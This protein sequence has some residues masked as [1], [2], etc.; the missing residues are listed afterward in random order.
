MRRSLQVSARILTSPEDFCGVA[1]VSRDPIAPYGLRFRDCV[2]VTLLRN[3]KL[4][5]TRT[6]EAGRYPG[7]LRS[8]PALARINASLAGQIRTVGPLSGQPIYMAWRRLLGALMMVAL[9][10]GAMIATKDVTRQQQELHLALY[11][12]CVVI[13]LLAVE[14]QTHRVALDRSVAGCPS[15]RRL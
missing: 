13:G 4:I 5:M 6:Q 8:G 12:F 7:E 10:I 11:A 3:D 1:V 9:A 14:W 2:T 15:G